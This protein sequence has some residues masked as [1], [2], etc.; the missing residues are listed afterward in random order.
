MFQT[1]FSVRNNFKIFGQKILEKLF[2]LKY[3][4]TSCFDKVNYR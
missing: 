4:M 3:V 1:S 2:M